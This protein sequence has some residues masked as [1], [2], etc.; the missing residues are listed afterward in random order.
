MAVLSRVLCY[1]QFIFIFID[2]FNDCDGCKFSVFHEDC[3]VY[4]SRG[5]DTGFLGCHISEEHLDCFFRL[6]GIGSE[7]MPKLLECEA[8]MGLY[9]LFLSLG[10]HWPHSPPNHFSI[11]LDPFPSSLKMEAACCPKNMCKTA[12]MDSVKAQKTAFCIP[13]DIRGD[14]PFLI[15]FK[16][17]VA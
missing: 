2:N 8:L 4:C 1:F 5:C 15:P 11:I 10:S 17:L 13:L 12:Q 9:P 7:L 16:L 3:S 14:S 6:E